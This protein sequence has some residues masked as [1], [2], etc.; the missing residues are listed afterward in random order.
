M[1]TPKEQVRIELTP[2]QR[3]M[4]ENATGKNAEVLELSVMELEERIA[5]MTLD[6][7]S[8]DGAQR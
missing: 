8:K 7:G 2:E 4:I 1:S 5:P 6:A 3:A